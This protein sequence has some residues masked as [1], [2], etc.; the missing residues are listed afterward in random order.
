MGA[1]TVLA[2]DPGRRD[3]PPLPINFTLVPPNALV[4]T[5]GRIIVN[6]R[7]LP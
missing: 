5:N 2:S 4:A 6:P 7:S 3:V 1:A